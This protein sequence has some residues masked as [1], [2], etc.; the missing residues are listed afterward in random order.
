M[1]I[2]TGPLHSSEARGKVGGPTGLVYNTH[3]GRA[4]VK[5]NATP[6]L[7]YTNP[8]VATRALMNTIIAAWQA[9]SDDRRA[10]W[11]H[12]AD[13]NHLCDW[14][15]QL[16][17][18]TGWNWFAKANSP[19]LYTSQPLLTEPPFPL[20]SYI[21]HD[22]A[23]SGAI[24]DFYVTWTPATPAPDPGW[25]IIMWAT[26]FHLPTVHPSIKRA[27]RTA[28]ASEDSGEIYFDRYIPG[29]VTLYLQPVS[30][31]GISM[32]PSRLLVEVT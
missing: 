3:R 1:A 8:Q 24:P 4:Y 6:L 20:T 5:A 13:E 32:P 15:G 18:I 26:D 2:V 30:A 23:Y 9:L 14:T 12:F 29:F 7:E 27:K 17:R 28:W 10:A 31:Q 16:K 25:A 22:L 21:L 19:L 11:Q